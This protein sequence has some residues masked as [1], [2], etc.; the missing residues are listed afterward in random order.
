MHFARLRRRGRPARGALRAAR[1]GADRGRR[2]R[3]E[4]R[5]SAAA[6]SAPSASPARSGSS[7]TRC[8]PPAR[9]ACWPPTTTRSPRSRARALPCDDDGILGAPPRRPR[10]LR[11]AG[12]RLQL[13]DRR[14]TGRAAALAAARACED[15]ID[16][17][18]EL[19]RRYRAAARRLPGW[20]CRSA[21]RRRDLLL[22]RD[23]G[24]ARGPA[25]R[26][27]RC[28]IALRDSTACRRASSIPRFTS[29]PPTASAS[30]RRLAAADRARRPQR[31]HAPAVPAH[32]RGTQDRVVDALRRRS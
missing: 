8:C 30:R 17:R 13:P 16:R 21:M 2:A 28:G 5:R 9:A 24:H 7:P 22:L 18:R 23:A 10:R 11:R 12:A 20:S 1:P 6:S 27:A 4:R 32:D 3:A 26:K 31:G 19:T 15:D 29:S 14:A 25:A